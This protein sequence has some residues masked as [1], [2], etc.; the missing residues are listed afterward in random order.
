VEKGG[1]FMGQL[2]IGTTGLAQGELLP[3]TAPTPAPVAAPEEIAPGTV[4]HALPA[5]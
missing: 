3:E 5:T 1:I 2:I 4:P